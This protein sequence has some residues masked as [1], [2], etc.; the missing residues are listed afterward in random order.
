MMSFL[1]IKTPGSTRGGQ[2]YEDE[3]REHKTCL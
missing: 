1:R 2:N 3:G